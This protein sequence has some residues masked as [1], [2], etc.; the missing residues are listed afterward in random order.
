MV[1]TIVSEGQ[2]WQKP[3]DTDEVVL[4]YTARI[5]DPAAAKAAGADGEAGPVVASSPEGGAVFT[6]SEAPCSGLKAAVTTMKP[7]IGRAHV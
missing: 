5:T 2:G 4:T 3:N 6:V 1:K 7:Q